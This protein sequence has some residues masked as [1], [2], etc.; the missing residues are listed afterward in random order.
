MSV[1]EDFSGIDVDVMLQLR[2][3][4][5]MLLLMMLL[6]LFFVVVL[7]LLHMCSICACHRSLLSTMRPSRRCSVTFSIF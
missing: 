4:K 7:M 3:K 1:V 6:L 2:K 5:Q